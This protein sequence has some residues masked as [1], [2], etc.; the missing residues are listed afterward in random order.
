MSSGAPSRSRDPRATIVDVFGVDWVSAVEDLGFFLFTA[1]IGGLIAL[2]GSEY[3]RRRQQTHE[4]E[5]W[6]REQQLKAYVNLL[7]VGSDFEAAV[8]VMWAEDDHS[9]IPDALPNYVSAVTKLVPAT[10]Q[11][12]VVGPPDVAT[13]AEGYHD[14]LDE[15]NRLLIKTDKKERAK[16]PSLWAR[17]AATDVKTARSAFVAAATA[18][19]NAQSTSS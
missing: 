1:G 14:A 16:S 5:S 11:V 9:T 6:L 3:G 18:V 7:D 17:P 4:N 2:G 12:L 13:A 10:S 8:S 19:M 15:L